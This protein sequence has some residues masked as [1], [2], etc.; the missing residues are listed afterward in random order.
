MIASVRGTVAAVSLQAAVVE[1]GGVGLRVLCTPSTLAGLRVGQQTSLSTALVV[2]EDSMTLFAFRDDDERDMF[3]LVQSASGIGPKVAQ[4]MLAV[5][6]PDQLRRAIAGADLKALT[7]V[8][9]IGQKGAQRIVLELK[10]RIGVTRAGVASGQATGA[11][12]AASHVEELVEALVG[13]GWSAREAA[14]AVDSV[15]ADHDASQPPD[16][17]ALL[18]AALRTLSR[19]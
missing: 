13:L 5:H 16:L 1:V 12:A 14:R 3:E 8:P 18:K 7:Q 6:G 19:A 9:G 10:D 17:A 2:R 11:S 15:T 4:A